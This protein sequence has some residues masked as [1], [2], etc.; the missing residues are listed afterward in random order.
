MWLCLGPHSGLATVIKWTNLL[1][2][3]SS[4]LYT[5]VMIRVITDDPAYSKLG[6]GI[7]V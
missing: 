1:K 4:H 3:P 5:K 7:P 6:A 2:V